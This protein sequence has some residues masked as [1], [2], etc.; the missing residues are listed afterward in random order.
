MPSS[1]DSVLKL[2][3]RHLTREAQFFLDLSV[4]I[5]SFGLAYCLRFDFLVPREV[6]QQAA[7]QLPFVVLLEF[8]C[9]YAAGVY[10]FVWRYIGLAELKSFLKAAAYATLPLFALRFGLTDE[11]GLW[12]VPL[13]VIM[14]NAATAFTGVVLLRVLRRV[15]YESYERGR[16]QG[17]KSH[18]TLLV[19]AGRAGIRVASE[20]RSHPEARL[21]ILGFLD[22]DPRKH[23]TVIQGIK[24]LG[25][26]S[27][28]QQL[29]D[30][31]SIEMVVVSMNSMSRREMRRIFD[32]CEQ[33]G[34]NIKIIPGIW[35]LLGDR[36]V[37]DQL[38]EIQVE[39]LLGRDPVELDETELRRFLSERAV[40]VTGAGGSIGSEIVRQICKIGPSQLILVERSEPAL[41]RIEQELRAQAPNIECI[42]VVAD[43]GDVAAME[44]TFA[45]LR[46]EVV[47]HAAA[48][49]HVPMLEQ[50]A[51]EGIKNNVFGTRNLGEVAAQFD[52][53]TFVLIST[54]KA[55][56]PTSVMGATKRLAELVIQDLDSRYA[57]RF[58]AVRF[59]NVLGSEGSAIQIF[60]EQIRRGG[61]VTV[62]HEDMVRYFMTI[63]E[64][65]Q[66][67]L[68]AGGLGLGGD[69]LML[70]MGEPVKILDLAKDMIRLSGLQPYEDI[71]IF[72]TGIRPGEKLFEELRISGEEFHPTR[73][74]KIFSTRMSS[75]LPTDDL[76]ATLQLL[77]KLIQNAND[78]E[79]KGCLAKVL[80]ENHLSL[81]SLR[82]DDAPRP[83]DLVV[84]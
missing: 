3:H 15:V 34:I 48:H 37:V 22:R 56:R 57:T 2:W 83:L 38:R 20:A 6:L 71:D 53:D 25:D 24:V 77:E 58:L 74:R 11:L 32:A 81:V 31:L 35:E 28:L 68:Q 33:K 64:A 67:V 39:D 40:M 21:E 5:A 78:D 9:L 82:P 1:P 63:P 42:P 30:E 47:F 72:I 13:S 19:G 54:D 10:S 29:V 17:K 16:S 44:R 26:P 59:G 41:F 66:L 84:H 18:R 51:A 27:L 62:T 79:I 43:V 7:M 61:P 36:V 14:I 46:P 23:G 55:V 80:P 8:V 70:D 60:S 12:R 75:P 73:H 76:A 65:A 50:N 69:I 45:R 4:L 52:V 49:K